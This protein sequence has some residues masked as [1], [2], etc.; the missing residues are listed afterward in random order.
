MTKVILFISYRPD[1]VRHPTHINWCY[2]LHC[3]E[4]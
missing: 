3:H 4:V 1:A 2:T